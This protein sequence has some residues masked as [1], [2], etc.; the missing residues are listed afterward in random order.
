M[1]HPYVKNFG[2]IKYQPKNVHQLIKNL[3]AEQSKIEAQFEWALAIDIDTTRLENNLSEIRD[4]ITDLEAWAK[5]DAL[6]WKEDN[7]PYFINVT[8]RE[9]G[10]KWSINIT[11]VESYY[12]STVSKTPYGVIN[13][14]SGKSLNV[15]ETAEQI[16]KLIEMGMIAISSVFKN[17]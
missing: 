3:K 16:D 13:L 14:N 7:M 5:E 15:V 8:S 1:D 11:L 17:Q 2:G 6:I 9:T 10:N 12:T 4:C